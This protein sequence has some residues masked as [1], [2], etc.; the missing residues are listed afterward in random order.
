MD[1]NLVLGI[2]GLAIAAAGI[3]ISFILARSQRPLYAIATTALRGVAHPDLA[4]AFNG[5]PIPNVYAVRFIL[6]NGGRK[7]I[8]KEDIPEDGAGPMVILVKT[9]EL[10]A[11]NAQTTTGD[12]T[13][14]LSALG[15]GR[16]SVHFD[17]LNKEDAILGEILCT[18]P[19][20]SDPLARFA[21]VIK[22]AQ[23]QAGSSRGSFWDDIVGRG[24]FLVM[25][26]FFGYVVTKS[27][28]DV[29]NPQWWHLMALWFTPLATC[30]LV[31]F[32]S[33][34]LYFS[35]SRRTPKKYNAFL[36]GGAFPPLL[37]R[38]T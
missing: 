18:S 17:F 24:G 10:L 34:H 20:G 22:G 11:L 28:H 19:D 14:K 4:I 2:G 16:V 9:V 7:E 29:V 30:A 32:A 31:L 27:A 33:W 1:I 21:G 5:R 12:E 6:W 35:I 15:D 8:R 23:L 13:G 3:A 37:G 25:V 26:L 38:R 36:S